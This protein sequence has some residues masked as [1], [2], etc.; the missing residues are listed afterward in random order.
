MVIKQFIIL[1]VVLVVSTNTFPQ[2]FEQTFN[3]DARFQRVHNTAE[4]S[5][6]H[7]ATLFWR[8][9]PLGELHLLDVQLIEDSVYSESF[10][11]K[12]E[13]YYFRLGYIVPELSD[14]S[15]IG[16]ANAIRLIDSGEVIVKW[17]YKSN[18]L[19]LKEIKNVPGGLNFGQLWQYVYLENGNFG[20]FV[21]DFYEP[22]WVL[23]MLTLDQNFNLIDSSGFKFTAWTY[24]SDVVLQNDSI[25]V[26]G[27]LG[28][29]FKVGISNFQTLDTTANPTN[30]TFPDLVLVKSA[31]ID[32]VDSSCIV[33]AQ[34]GMWPIGSDRYENVNLSRFTSS[35]TLL[36]SYSFSS[37]DSNTQTGIVSQLNDYSMP[38]KPIILSDRSIIFGTT[39]VFN[40]DGHPIFDTTQSTIRVFK[41]NGD[42]EEQWRFEYIDTNG[43]HLY[44]YDM[45]A[46][47]DGTL[48]AYCFKYDYENQ[49]DDDADILILR[50]KEDGTFYSLNVQEIEKQQASFS[51]FP[52]PA[53]DVVYIS[54]E[55]NNMQSFK[56]FD[57]NGRVVKNGAITQTDLNVSDLKTGVYLLEITEKSGKR[58]V[59]RVVIGE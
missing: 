25:I 26:F 28:D 47:Q 31:I 35:G 39:S 20:L 36:G 5:E 45:H 41:L 24:F 38:A 42:L 49:P 16:F 19:T 33:L 27:I 6:N 52:N 56:V 34:E 1:C 15:I 21:G 3:A 53:K 4:L 48:L 46:L 7:W 43:V 23:S 58:S 30:W 54:G 11:L 32:K 8:Y 22:D 51:V 13:E 10:Q 40:N 17:A 37:I 18:A 50:I 55:V 2:S 9:S 29:V 59:V 12:N 57:M 14:D 44:L